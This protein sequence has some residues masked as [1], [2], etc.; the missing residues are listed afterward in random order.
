MQVVDY[1]DVQ[2]TKTPEILRALKLD[3]LEKTDA[4]KREIRDRGLAG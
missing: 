3:G 1:R 4:A 2:F